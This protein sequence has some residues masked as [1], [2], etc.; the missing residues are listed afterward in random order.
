MPSLLSSGPTL[1][2]KAQAVWNE[3]SG[4]CPPL[5]TLQTEPTNNEAPETRKLRTDNPCFDLLQTDE[6]PSYFIVFLKTPDGTIRLSRRDLCKAYGCA[7]QARQFWKAIKDGLEDLLKQGD[8][9]Y[10]DNYPIASQQ[11]WKSVSYI[12][13]SSIFLSR[14]DAHANIDVFSE[15]FQVVMEHFLSWQSIDFKP[16]AYRAL[17]LDDIDILVDTPPRPHMRRFNLRPPYQQVLAPFSH[18]FILYAKRI[19]EKH[20]EGIEDKWFDL[21]EELKPDKEK[22]QTFFFPFNTPMGPAE[23]VL[24][25]RSEGVSLPTGWKM[26]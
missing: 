13:K 9:R 18:A 4:F 19:L 12:G 14:H 2:T 20:D 22:Y 26:G 1:L 17:P 7:M 3:F 11:F 6:D 15:E 16:S 8:T 5:W 25:K 21:W 23:L 10:K 24:K